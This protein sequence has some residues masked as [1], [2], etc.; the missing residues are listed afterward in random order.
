MDARPKTR[1]VV[2]S[3]ERLRWTILDQKLA[4]GIAGQR[5]KVINYAEGKM[6]RVFKGH[7]GGEWLCL[8]NK[9]QE[10]VA[11]T[12]GGRNL[13]VLDVETGEAVAM[14]K[15]SGKESRNSTPVWYFMSNPDGH[16]SA[17]ASMLE[18]DHLTW[19]I[20]D[21]P[22]RSLR[23]TLTA[24][25]K[26]DKASMTVADSVFTANCR[27]FCCKYKESPEV[28]SDLAV[29]DLDTGK[30]AHRLFHDRGGSV[31]SVVA[32]GDDK[33]LVSY[34]EK[35]IDI[36][37]WS[38]P[39]GEQLLRL[40]GHSNRYVD[41][42][43]LTEDERHLV[44]YQSLSAK[45]RE[46][47]LWDLVAGKKIAGFT[48]EENSIIQLACQGNIIAVG[49]RSIGSIVTFSLTGSDVIRSELSSYAGSSQTTTASEVYLD[50]ID[51][52]NDNKADLDD[53]DSDFDDDEV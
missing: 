17:V 27:Y 31:T 19:Y 45:E 50:L 34:C 15:H 35:S 38:L 9:R 53:I 2:E 14:L 5:I 39:Q 36:L 37:L 20:W 6:V 33:I 47:I 12:R 11:I 44:S 24:P 43:L 1:I 8:V 4:V 52:E 28:N 40:P 21:V 46:F 10:I 7:T 18:G 23:H 25:G 13:K 51:P 26:S 3:S 42:L 16:G 49:A 41:R 22:S 30:V 32:M 48:V 29:W